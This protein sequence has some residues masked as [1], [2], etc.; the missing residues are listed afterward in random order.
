MRRSEYVTSDVCGEL[1]A[2]D[3]PHVRS[4]VLIL[5]SWRDVFF[6]KVSVFG[7]SLCMFFDV[8]YDMFERNLD[9]DLFF[10]LMIFLCPEH[11]YRQDCRRHHYL[12]HQHQQQH[13]FIPLL[14]SRLVLVGNHMVSPR[15]LGRCPH[16]SLCFDCSGCHVYRLCAGFKSVGVD[17]TRSMDTFAPLH[18]ITDSFGVA[19]KSEY[20]KFGPKTK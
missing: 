16:S 6:M 5:S 9:I 3:L 13:A 8:S 17:P 7:R 2:F 14:C 15:L 19:G 20:K 1:V 12:R 11:Y 4:T 18:I 10:R